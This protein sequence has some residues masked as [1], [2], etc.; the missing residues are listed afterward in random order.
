MQSRSDKLISSQKKPRG[1]LSL[2]P[3]GWTDIFWMTF[4]MSRHLFTQ[5]RSAPNQIDLIIYF[6]NSS[7]LSLSFS[8]F[9]LL[10]YFIVYGNIIFVV[11]IFSLSTKNLL[12]TNKCPAQVVSPFSLTVMTVNKSFACQSNVFLMSN[13]YRCFW[14]YN[15]FRIYNCCKIY[16]CCKS[17]K[18]Q[19]SG[20][21]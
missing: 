12:S 1:L 20:D 13:K 6:T 16:K 21:S 5:L 10:I 7:L 9:K 17:F 19:R 14:I 2:Q 11:K 4:S 8:W 18:C 15:C 3:L